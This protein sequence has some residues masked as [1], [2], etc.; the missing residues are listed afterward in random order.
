[1]TENGKMWLADNGEWALGYFFAATPAKA[2]YAAAKEDWDIDGGRRPY[3]V[4]ADYLPH[5]RLRRAPGLDAHGKT[6]R[7]NTDNDLSAA[8]KA[9]L[10]ADR[11]GG[12]DDVF[13]PTPKARAEWEKMERELSE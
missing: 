6:I 8:Y 2:R 7:I 10:V 12:D 1:M 3:A 4:A 11:G 9:G 13:F 5:I